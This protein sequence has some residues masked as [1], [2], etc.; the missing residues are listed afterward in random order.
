MPAFDELALLDPEQHD[1]RVRL[2]FP[3]R[4]EVSEML[5]LLG[6]FL[7][8]AGRPPV[9]EDEVAVGGQMHDLEPQV[10]IRLTDISARL[11]HP[12]HPR[13]LCMERRMVMVMIS[14]ALMQ[15]IDIAGHSLRVPVLDEPP[16]KL[17]VVLDRHWRSSPH[18]PRWCGWGCGQYISISPPC[19]A[20]SD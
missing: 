9:H 17:L 15:D 5:H 8:R 3:G 1:A 11:F 2:L 19:T 14:V 13:V 7:V 16:D 10:R 6:L 20:C 18:E 12:V 4:F